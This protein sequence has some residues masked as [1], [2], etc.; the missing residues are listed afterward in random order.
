[1]PYPFFPSTTAPHPRHRPRP[2]L[3]VYL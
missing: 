2:L 3:S 1:L